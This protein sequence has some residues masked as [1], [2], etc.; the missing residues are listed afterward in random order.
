MAILRG[1]NE[2]MFSIRVEGVPDDELRVLRLRGEEGMSELFH[3]DLELVSDNPNIEFAGVVGKAAALLIAGSESDR[4]V[5]GIVSRFEQGAIGK[6]FTRYFLQIVPRQWR[7]LQREDTRVFQDLSVHDI[8]KKVV[9]DSGI[10]SKALRSTLKATYP[11]RGYCVQYQESDWAFVSR[12]L[13][14]EG[15]FYFFEHA[16]DEHVMVLGDDPSAHADIEGDSTVVYRD[17]TGA[18]PEVEYVGT[19]RYA[20]SVRTGK[21][22]MRDYN[23]EKPN[24]N[25]EANDQAD[26]ESDLESFEYLPGRYGAAEEGRRLA[27]VRLGER[28][29]L[30]KVGVG[31]SVCRRLTP[32]YRFT[33]AEHLRESSNACW[34]VT[35]LTHEG[36]EPQA[37]EQDAPEAG[38][39][40]EY[41]NEFRCIPADVTY[42][43]LRVTP[44]PTIS[45]PQVAMVVG[46]KG[47]EIYT[48]EYGR[49]K[50]Q[51]VW[52]RRG[53]QD[54]KSSCWVRTAQQALGGSMVIPRIGWEVL[55]EFIGGDVNQ[56]V[57]VGRLWNANH[58]PPYSLPDQK[59]VTAL[60]SSTTPGGGGFNEIRLDDTDGAE[61]IFLHAQKQFDARIGCDSYELVGKE[62]HLIVKENQ[63]MRVEGES[64]RKVVGDDIAELG[65]DLHLKVK[66]KQA[67]EIGESQSLTVKGDVIE[68]FKANHS[69]QVTQNYYVKAMGVVI[70]AMTGITIKCGP[71]SYI[72][73]D[74]SGVTLKGMSLALDGVSVRIASGPGSPAMSGQAGSAVSPIAPK[75]AQE[76]DEAD[77][78]K[79][80]E[81]KAEQMAEK[82]GKYGAARVAPWKPEAV[83]PGEQS[84]KSWIEIELVDEDGNPV[85]GE[86]YEITLP[87]GTTVARGTLDQN[88]FA[89]VSGCDPGTCR[90]TFP[91]L[92][93]DA[94]EP[95]G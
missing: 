64:H 51:F 88:G 30:R 61:Q 13:E 2:A 5:N 31:H 8:V 10:P 66:G 90:I 62:A 50:V 72:V 9:E 43:P 94:W 95:A 76:A 80:K 57:V 12:L 83:A 15:I 37:L 92:D 1:G 68:V 70:E 19:F 20:E 11:P 86:P 17:P 87:D 84:E 77:P 75:E 33:L 63:L 85:P 54:E 25:L 73:I 78:N 79:M 39:E 23:F 67:I 55:V 69:E 65:K 21:V 53:K 26:G 74:P 38:T 7:L 82:K 4:Y 59:N 93:R 40:T 52:D 32:G 71:T 42:R 81:I 6:K 41:T 36:Y 3:F 24:T 28:Q 89:R 22:T 58:M 46:P 27:K 48:D 56:P 35:D 16:E 18:L 45:G 91:R 47:E 49:V 14:E 60:K 34:L 44:R 29:A